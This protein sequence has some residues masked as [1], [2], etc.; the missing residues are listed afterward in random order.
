M[1]LRTITII[2]ILYIYTLKLDTPWTAAALTI[3]HMIKIKFNLFHHTWS[4]YTSRAHNHHS[5]PIS[6][7]QHLLHNR[8][9]VAVFVV[10][11]V[12]FL[13]IHTHTHT[14]ACV[15]VCVIV[16]RSF[17]LS[18]RGAETNTFAYLPHL[19]NRRGRCFN[20]K[21]TFI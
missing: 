9:R 19:A 10:F 12:C 6:V 7:T 18:I 1:C 11:L 4:H 16:C 21:T 14:I 17:Q 15:C 2:I 8:K 5:A 13:H 3:A 20:F